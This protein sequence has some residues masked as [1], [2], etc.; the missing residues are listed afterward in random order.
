MKMQTAQERALPVTTHSE[1]GGTENQASSSKLLTNVGFE[2]QERHSSDR[3]IQVSL[4]SSSATTVQPVNR[5]KFSPVTPPPLETS[6]SRAAP[7]CLHWAQSPGAGSHERLQLITRCQS[8]A[9]DSLNPRIFSLRGSLKSLISVL[10]RTALS[11]QTR[12]AESMG[13][14]SSLSG[15]QDLEFDLERRMFSR[16]LDL[17][18]CSGDIIKWISEEELTNKRGLVEAEEML[19]YY[20]RTWRIR[21]AEGGGGLKLPRT[22]PLTGSPTS[23]LST[24]HVIVQSRA[25]TPMPAHETPC[26]LWTWSQP[27]SSR[28]RVAYTELDMRL[29]LQLRALHRRDFFHHQRHRAIT[30]SVWACE[31]PGLDL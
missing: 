8:P 7:G 12:G 26:W 6:P 16:V 2:I 19:W 3:P 29:S 1:A 15:F 10:E 11:T 28:G 23:S 4:L 20:S 21:V 22:A 5:P 30:S 25:G 18:R 31:L 27:D 14:A 17:I 24:N 13:D 9:A